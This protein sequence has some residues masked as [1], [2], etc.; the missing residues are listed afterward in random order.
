ML[1]YARRIAVE[2]KR[3]ETHRKVCRRGICYSYTRTYIR[4]S[5]YTPGPIFH[6]I[7]VQDSDVVDGGK[8]GDRNTTTDQRGKLESRS[9]SPVIAPLNRNTAAIHSHPSFPFPHSL[10]LFLPLVVLFVLYRRA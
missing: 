7:G 8:E 3:R 5:A 9:D 1:P 2:E 4:T 10:L 6:P